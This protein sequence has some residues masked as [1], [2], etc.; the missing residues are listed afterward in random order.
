V[1]PLLVAALVVVVTFGGALAGIRLRELLP[2][3]HLDKDSSDTVKLAFGLIATMTALVLGL[4]T[5]SAKNTLD[6]V[7]AAVNHSATEVLTLDRA[8]A[9][10]GPETGEIR[11]LLYDTLASRIDAIWPKEGGH[12]DLAVPDVRRAEL[13]A[14][15]IQALAPHSEEQTWL[16]SRALVTAESLLAS[17]WIAEAVG[18]TS[19]VEP[20]L[21]ALLFWLGITFASFGLFAPRNVT[22]IC[23]LLVCA[24]SVASAVFLVL[25][26]NGPF[27]GLLKVSPEP[28]RY[29]L[30]QMNR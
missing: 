7:S 10:Y 5:A 6:G 30:S 14:T 23:V 8:L 20:F 26:M 29:A 4:I 12:S 2:Q 22:V 13:I 15:R 19:V 24:V 17:R 28:L 3:A 9:R 1:N 27:E 11:H 25:E 21:A 18:D 16:R